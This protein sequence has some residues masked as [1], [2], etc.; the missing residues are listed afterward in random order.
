MNDQAHPGKMH[1]YNRRGYCFVNGCGVHRDDGLADAI[2][3]VLTKAK[4]PELEAKSGADDLEKLGKR[5]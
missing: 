4:K 1:A 3:E 2:C 5:L